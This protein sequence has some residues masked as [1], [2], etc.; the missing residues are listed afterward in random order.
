MMPAP[1]PAAAPLLRLYGVFLRLL[2]RLFI[3]AFPL[4]LSF[5][6]LS[7]T[8]LQLTG[9]GSSVGRAKAPTLVV[10]TMKNGGERS[11][12]FSHLPVSL[13]V[14]VLLA[15]RLALFVGRG[16]WCGP[17]ENRAGLGCRCVRHRSR[18]A[19][20]RQ[21]DRR[22]NHAAGRRVRRTQV[23]RVLHRVGEIRL[24]SCHEIP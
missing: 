6:G 3:D 5:D 16:K 8:S 7:L 15:L 1:G 9:A 4:T 22:A 21:G 19:V 17:D 24:F 2:K 11:P 18:P 20:G 10:V 12:P 14:S 13:Q 23:A